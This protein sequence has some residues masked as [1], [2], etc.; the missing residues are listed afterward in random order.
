MTQVMCPACGA[1]L[2]ERV[3]TR[4]VV[5]AGSEVELPFRR[6]TDHVVCT[7]CLAAYPVNDFQ[8]EDAP[9]PETEEDLID[10]LERL[11]EHPPDQG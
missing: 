5:P 3:T 7:E 6:T 1:V 4:G 2:L 8:V 10:R 9:E 11:A